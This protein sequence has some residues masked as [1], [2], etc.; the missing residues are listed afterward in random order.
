MRF[1]N[2]VTSFY[3]HIYIN[4]IFNSVPNT[5]FR[6]YVNV[7]GK[8]TYNAGVGKGNEDHFIVQHER[9]DDEKGIFQ[10]RVEFISYIYKIFDFEAMKTTQV[11]LLSIFST[12]FSCVL[13]CVQ[14]RWGD[15]KGGF[16]EHY[17][18]LNHHKP[19]DGS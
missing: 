4:H 12:R 10:K 19:L 11:I 9:A 8:G 15:K 16:G 7:M 18:D 1:E 5:S 3:V 2:Y 17:Y 14:V 13:I 6:R